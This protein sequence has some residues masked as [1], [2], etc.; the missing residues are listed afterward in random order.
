MRK[1]LFV[2]LG[3][4]SA[5]VRIKNILNDEM[6]AAFKSLITECRKLVYKATNVVVCT[7]ITS[8]V[9]VMAASFK[10]VLVIFQKGGKIGPEL[11]LGDRIQKL[12]YLPFPQ[13]GI[14]RNGE[15]KSD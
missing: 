11:R 1:A 7:L 3:T 8:A 14:G 9:T 4:S 5:S 6:A 10:P 13:V 15:L 12:P 2:D